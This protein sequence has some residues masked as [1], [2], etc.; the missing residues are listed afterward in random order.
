MGTIPLIKFTILEKYKYTLHTMAHLTILE[1][2]FCHTRVENLKGPVHLLVKCL[3]CYFWTCFF[4]YG[5]VKV[6]L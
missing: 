3:H 6:K 2:A 5:T 1:C 4:P